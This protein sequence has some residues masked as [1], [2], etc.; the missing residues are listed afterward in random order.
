[1]LAPTW[2]P[3]GRT[4]DPELA[5]RRPC[6]SHGRPSLP[7]GIQPSATIYRISTSGL[8][9][10][11]VRSFVEV[12]AKGASGE[13]GTAG[14]PCYRRDPGPGAQPSADA[15]RHGCLS[16]FARA[17]TAARSSRR[18]LLAA[19]RPGGTAPPVRSRARSAAATSPSSQHERD[20]AHLRG[21]LARPARA[22]RT[23]A[24]DRARPGKRRARSRARPPRPPGRQRRG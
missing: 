6:R 21:T 1:M 9:D 24:P 2:T 4:A 8:L 22:A 20:L 19:P 12:C 14:Q 5:R 17:A 7:A 3:P 23:R 16:G 18:D 10:A 11:A 13:A 15:S